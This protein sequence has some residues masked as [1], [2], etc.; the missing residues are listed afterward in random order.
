MLEPA[1]AI[2]V[3]PVKAPYVAEQ[4]AFEQVLVQGGA[5]HGHE[6]LVLARAVVVERLG[7][8]LLAGAGLA[9]GSAPWPVGAM[10]LS[11]ATTACIAAD[12][13]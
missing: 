1:L 2:A 12:C 3:G 5:I 9:R 13:R 10:R 8:Q 6:R 4:L 11:L 7:D